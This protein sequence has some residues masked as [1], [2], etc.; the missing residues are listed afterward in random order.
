[1]LRSRKSIVDWD[2]Y[3]RVKKVASI[4]HIKQWRHWRMTGI[5]F[6]FCDVTY[7]QPNR[8]TATFV[9]GTSTKGRHQGRKDNIKGYF[10]DILIGPYTAFGVQCQGNHD[11]KNELMNVVN[12]GTGVEQHQHNTVDLALFNIISWMWEFEV[13]NY[14][15]QSNN[16]NIKCLVIKKLS[17]CL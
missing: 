8:S 6:E 4:I 16:C 13:N 2:Y 1:M 3:S 9:E 5:A 10:L 12:K 7:T 17:I 15:K 14:S 11:D